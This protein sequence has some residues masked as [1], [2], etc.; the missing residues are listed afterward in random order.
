MFPFP[1][2]HPWTFLLAAVVWTLTSPLSHGQHGHQGP[3]APPP[4]PHVAHT[5]PATPP[6]HHPPAHKQMPVHTGGKGTTSIGNNSGKGPSTTAGK[7]SKPVVSGGEG[8]D[9]GKIRRPG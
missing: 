3:P 1:P 5:K 8:K 4:A 9:S 6:A 7:G 2:K